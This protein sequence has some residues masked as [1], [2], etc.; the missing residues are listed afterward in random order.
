MKQKACGLSYSYCG[1]DLDKKQKNQWMDGTRNNA[2]QR[3]HKV[4]SNWCCCI[5]YIVGCF[6]NI[7]AW[8]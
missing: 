4:M 5:F 7:C 8:P 1:P 2:A 3:P 6:Y